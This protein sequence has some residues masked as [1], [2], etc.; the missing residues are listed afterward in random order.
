MQQR[1]A[2]HL[3][4]RVVAAQILPQTEKLAV[5]GQ[6]AAVY[7]LGGLIEGSFPQCAPGKCAYIIFPSGN[8]TEMWKRP[9]RSG[10]QNS[11]VR[12]AAGDGLGVFQPETRHSIF[13]EKNLG[14]QPLLADM[15]AE[16]VIRRFDQPL[17]MQAAHHQF[18]QMLGR[19]DQLH[20]KPGVEKDSDVVLR[21]KLERSV[22]GG[23]WHRAGGDRKIWI[24]RE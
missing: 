14:F 11:I 1:I 5:F 12:A 17:R 24:H 8:G 7:R 3:I 10:K 15:K 9:I 18:V 13:R 4:Q 20:G 19:A 23:N 21:R 16:D 2:D 22:F 6:G